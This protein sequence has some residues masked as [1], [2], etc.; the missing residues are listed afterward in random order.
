MSRNINIRDEEILLLG[1]CR[2]TFNAELKVMLKALA[3]GTID[4]KYFATLANDHGVAAL[5]YHNLQRLDFLDL[6]TKDSAVSLKNSMM[7][8]LCR[9]TVNL[10]AAGEVIS[11]LNHNRVNSVL[12]KGL[13]LEITVYGNKGL[14]QMTDAD[15]LIPE[16]KWRDAQKT[17]I[18][19][20]Y[21]S[22][23]VKSVFHRMIQAD[24]GKHL[25]T[26]EKN[27]FLL[28]L[29]LD[30]FGRKRPFLTKMLL[31][32]AE[33][34]EIMGL[35]TKIPRV[36]FFFLYL[37]RHLYMHELNNES[38]LRLYTDLV[39]LLEKHGDEILT[40]DLLTMAHDA[41]L[42][43]VLA[44]KLEPVRDLWGMSFPVWVNDFINKW[45]SPA[46]INDFVYFLKSPKGNPPKDKARI[47]KMNVSEIPGLCR[48]ILYVLGDLF[49]TVRFMKNRYRCKSAL[50]AVLYYPHRW[51]KLWYLMKRVQG[52]GGAV[53]DN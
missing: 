27:G 45:Y 11:L 9:N 35:K 16:D 24:T 22:G 46:S 34:A 26:L 25:P 47:Y 32:T 23:Q 33:E 52:T 50:K 6:V 36:P 4:W 5:I 43:E 2:L 28:D 48:K 40:A 29:H 21:K 10:R 3:E 53:H 19:A 49:P 31:D 15:M 44:R 1:L 51:G 13:A 38:Q 41:G 20:G 37:I 8:N 17:L 14:R 30:L 18:S 39:V 12:I 7:M 42:S